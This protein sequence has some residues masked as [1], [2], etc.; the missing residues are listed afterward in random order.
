[1]VDCRY[2]FEEC[3]SKWVGTIPYYGI[4]YETDSGETHYYAI[5]DIGMDGFAVLV[6]FEPKK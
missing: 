6:K 1:M 2:S 4:S 5:S 3:I